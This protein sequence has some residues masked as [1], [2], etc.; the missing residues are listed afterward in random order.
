MFTNL[1]DDMGSAY[2]P[3]I[4]KDERRFRGRLWAQE[5]PFDRLRTG[6]FDFDQ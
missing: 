5:M 4:R 1:R 2:G 3:D 6:P